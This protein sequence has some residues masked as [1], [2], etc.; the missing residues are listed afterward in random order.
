MVATKSFTAE[1]DLQANTILLL[2]L[3]R[4]EDYY[5]VNPEYFICFLFSYFS[6]P[7]DTVRNLNA[8]LKLTATQT[9]CSSQLVNKYFMHTKGRSSPAYRNLVRSK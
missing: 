7:A 9:I 4:L 5:I 1:A 2:I 6:Y 3:F 8:Y